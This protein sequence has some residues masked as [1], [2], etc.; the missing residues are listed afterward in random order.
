MGSFISFL[1]KQTV[2]FTVTNH[3]IHLTQFRPSILI[4][5]TTRFRYLANIWLRSSL[6]LLKFPDLFIIPI[7]SS[8]QKL[9]LRQQF[10]ADVH[11]ITYNTS[12]CGKKSEVFPFLISFFIVI[13][14]VKTQTQFS[15][16]L[17]IQTI[18]IFFL[19]FLFFS[20]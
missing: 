15:L 4:L 3:F 18:F 9:C 7:T 2:W 10:L 13:E 20:L 19:S 8:I 16:K 6:F 12:W 1:L 5:K 14:N 17:V 11:C